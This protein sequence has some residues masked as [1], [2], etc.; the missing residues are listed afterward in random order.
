MEGHKLGNPRGDVHVTAFSD[1]KVERILPK[2]MA[3]C[4]YTQKQVETLN[5]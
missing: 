5:R 1:K 2:K 4:R 3:K